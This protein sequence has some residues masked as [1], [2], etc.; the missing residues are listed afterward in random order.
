MDGREN[1]LAQ[2]HPAVVGNLL[3][4]AAS[5]TLSEFGAIRPGITMVLPTRDSTS[6]S[7]TED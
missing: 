6:V 4:D 7:P 2:A 3:F 1:P 5:R